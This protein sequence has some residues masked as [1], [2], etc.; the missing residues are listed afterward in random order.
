MGVDSLSITIIPVKIFKNV[1][2][3]DNIA[4]LI[5]RSLNSNNLQ[6]KDNDIL[7]IAQKVI[8]KSEDRIY[9][10]DNIVPS[11][12]ALEIFAIHKKDPR[13]IEL[14]LMESK[15]IIKVTDKVLI[16]ET[17][18]GFVCA[19]AGI[20]QSNVNVESDTVL[21]LPENPDESAKKIRSYIYHMLKKNVSVIISDTFGRPFR[22]GQTNV[23]IGVAGIC[24]LKS[25]I[26]KT[27]T[28]GKILKVTE[29]SIIDELA[30]AAE[31]VMGKTLEIPVAI[32]RGY[33][34]KI[35]DLDD[36]EVSIKSVFRE[37]SQD[38]FRS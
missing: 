38:V 23:A 26:G 28:F 4:I 8:S 2:K 35:V 3:N 9:H 14:I 31:L 12:K 7:V 32:I 24:P 37:K 10:L 17:K 1:D 33:G 5:H 29:I 6:I 36:S 19:N 30:S 27:D 22:K 18:H 13:L 25:Y 34:Y 21:L 20:D 11:K 16:V 15:D